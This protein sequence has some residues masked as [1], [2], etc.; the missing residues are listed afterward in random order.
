[1]KTFFLKIENLLLILVLVAFSLFPIIPNSIKGLPVVFFILITLLFLLF[2]KRV[3]KKNRY[4]KYAFLF[5]TLL[6]MYLVS[7]IYTSDLQYG[8]RKLETTLSFFMIPF[9]L[10]LVY[11]RIKIT[12]KMKLTFLYGYIFFAIIYAISI[13]L[14]F[15]YLGFDYCRGNLSH[16]LSYLNGM[17]IL[18]EH[19]IYASM[20]ISLAIIFIV[21]GFRKQHIFTKIIFL[22]CLSIIVFTLFFLIRKGVIIAL[23]LSFISFLFFGKRPK[24]VNYLKIVVL[25]SVLFVLSLSFKD[26]IFKRFSELSKSSTYLLVD[27]DNS[28]SIRYSVYKCSL[29]LISQNPIFGVG[30]GDVSH[31]LVECYKSK[32]PYLVSNRFNSHNQ[33]FGIILSTGFLGLLIFI[34][35]LVFYFKNAI[36]YKDSL[37]LQ[38]LIFFVFLM[39]T[40]NILDRQSGVILFSFTMNYFFFNNISAK[41]ENV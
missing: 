39:M 37:F 10:A 27:P 41:L 5:S 34:I 36:S 30:L 3:Y 15:N 8:L 24:K 6:L 20:F 25:L 16:C 33:F 13:L 2:K 9:C 4:I 14:Y 11:N 35:Q 29:F 26:S 12:D 1:V 28:T 40:E 21:N 7:L 32:S 19:P 23:A 17:F 22:L 38:S 31:E 18:S